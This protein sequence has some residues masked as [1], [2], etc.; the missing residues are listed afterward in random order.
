[1][2]PD[3][4]FAGLARGFQAAFHVRRLLGEMKR[5]EMRTLKRRKRRAPRSAAENFWLWNVFRSN[6]LW[7]EP[8][9]PISTRKG[10]SGM[11]GSFKTVAANVSSI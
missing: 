10:G 4:A 1:M 5:V 9:T 7:P 8:D 11:V 6:V 3:Q 2:S